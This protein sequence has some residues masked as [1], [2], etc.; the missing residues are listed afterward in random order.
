MMPLVLEEERRCLRA[1]YLEKGTKKPKTEI[2]KVGTPP[3]TYQINTFQI[4]GDLTKLSLLFVGIVG[5]CK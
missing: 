3:P 4:D 2:R 5:D 1:G